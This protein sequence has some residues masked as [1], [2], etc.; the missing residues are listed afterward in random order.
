MIKPY[1]QNFT[2]YVE[3]DI[4][5]AGVLKE[6]LYKVELST[7]GKSLIWKRAVPDYFFKSK[8][9]QT[10]LGQAYHPNQLRVIAHND[11]VQIIWKGGRRQVESILHL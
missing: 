9:M 7:Y 3:V 5:V 2:D 8:R 1:C 6:N 11:V 4:H 10:Q